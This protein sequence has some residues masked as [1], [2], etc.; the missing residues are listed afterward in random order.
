MRVKKG[1]C[2][3][4]TSHA[5]HVGVP[6][7]EAPFLNNHLINLA[8]RVAFPVLLLI[9][10]CSSGADGVPDHRIIGLCRKTTTIS[11]RIIDK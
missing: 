5:K 8:K 11:M 9:I 10:W 4:E 3:I 7:F 1:S 2:H 6:G